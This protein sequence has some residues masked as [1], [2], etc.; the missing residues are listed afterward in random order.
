MQV[1]QDK[2]MNL[3]YVAAN[4]YYQAIIDYYGGIFN[5]LLPSITV[6]MV[7]VLKI[8]GEI[9]ATG[10]I[11]GL[12]LGG[13]SLQIGFMAPSDT[14]W[15]FTNKPLTAGSRYAIPITTQK[16]SLAELE[17]LSEE[18]KSNIDPNLA[19]DDLISDDMIDTGLYL[20]GMLYFGSVD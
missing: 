12:G 1:N 10:S 2:K 6:G 8:D 14:D 19:D 3:V 9:V 5:V 17:R 20:T 16:T 7:P 11:I 13:Q 4:D 18:A 15:A